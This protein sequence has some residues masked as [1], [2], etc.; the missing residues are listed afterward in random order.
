MAFCEIK[1]LLLTNR[2]EAQ[3]GENLIKS[4]CFQQSLVQLD[5]QR[6]WPLSDSS[7][8]LQSH[9]GTVS[10]DDGLQ[11]S[12]LFVNVNEFGCFSPAYLGPVSIPR[13]NCVCHSCRLV[14]MLPSK[15]EWEMVGWDWQQCSDVILTW[16]L[17]ALTEARFV[18][19]I[20]WLQHFAYFVVS[21][22]LHFFPFSCMK[23]ANG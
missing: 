5:Q 16:M 19:V 8:R 18:T 4:K 12:D 6:K 14:W 11:F 7:D 9:P 10:G 17:D 3:Q 20:G 13:W 22:L 21:F 15:F 2:T 1:F 23:C